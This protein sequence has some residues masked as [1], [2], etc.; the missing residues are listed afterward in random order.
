MGIVVQKF[1]GRL[2]E[3]PGKIR[4]AAHYIVQTKLNGE[5]PIVVVSAPGRVTD[6]LVRWA[7]KVSEHPEGRELDM[8]LSVGERMAMALLALAINADGRFRA[9]SF[10]GSQVGI[11]TDTRHTDASIIEVKGFRIREAISQRQIPIIAGFQGISTEKEITTLGRGGS[12][13]TAVALAAALGADRCELI[14]ESGGIYSADPLQVPQAKLLPVIDYT[15]LEN[16]TQSGAKVVQPRAAAL[17]K[18]HHVVLSINAPDGRRGTLVVDRT[19]SKSMV[20]AITLRSGKLL[21]L[22]NGELSKSNFG[23]PS[24][25][26]WWSNDGVCSVSFGASALGTPVEVV[27][28]VGWG[29]LLPSEAVEISLAAVRDGELTPLAIFRSEGTLLIVFPNSIG[30]AALGELHSSILRAGLIEQHE[31]ENVG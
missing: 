25:L 8:L 11:I 12:D 2:L 5:D 16:M 18:E 30:K 26:F 27:T 19:L 3:S 28:V 7:G 10:T 29:G 31:P 1:G 13:A 14:K 15:T 20:S 21:T 4:R 23:S 22:K 24:E 9:V 17:A 6:H